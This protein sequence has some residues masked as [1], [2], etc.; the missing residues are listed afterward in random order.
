MRTLVE[1]Q[2]NLT[3]P[4]FLYKC[5]N[6]F[7][8]WCNVVLA[9][10][11]QIEYGGIKDFHLEWFNLIENNNRVVILAPSGFAKSTVLAVAY[12]LWIAFT[13][14]NK[15]I[16]I[17][18]KTLPQSLRLLEVMRVI[19]DSNE[20]LGDLKPQNADKSW[21]KQILR[22]TTNCRIFVRPYSINI[23]GER[24]DYTILDEAASYDRP[25]IYLDY[26][27]PRLNPNGRIVLIS[28]PESPVDLMT[29]LNKSDYINRT[30]TAEYEINGERKALWEERFPLEKLDSLKMEMGENYYEKNF[31][32]NPKAEEENAIFPFKIIESCLDEKRKLT[33]STEGGSIYIGVDLAASSGPRADF[34]CFTV[35]ERIG[36]FTVIKHGEV[37]KGW[38]I[39]SKTERINELASTFKENLVNIIVDQSN[40]GP[41][42][43]DDLRNL[44]LPV[45][46]QDFHPTN[47]NMLLMNLKKELE[48]K[49]L[50]IPFDQDDALTQT[51]TKK[52]ILELVKFKEVTTDKTG[53]RLTVA[54][55]ISAGSHDD[56]V[57]A[58]AMA[59]YGASLEKPFI[60]LIAAA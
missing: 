56:T 28:T 16:M 31:M 53:Q 19:I 25:E 60:D 2:G 10:L 23:K 5:K 18:S 11:F 58:L 24:V 40:I 27:V 17:V 43:I 8:F 48:N 20:L 4:E 3:I 32:C 52:L 57:M 21:S 22:T 1:M 26:I 33:F 34:D 44:G 15:Q 54:K 41:A 13:K 51:F 29:R 9:D 30:Y 35:V 47:R 6:D 50:I 38:S 14:T 7:K 59:C 55:Y 46:P 42:I 37:H 36:G 49:T 45:K 39:K 12:P